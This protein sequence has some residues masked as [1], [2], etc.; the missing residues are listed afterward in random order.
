VELSD[1]GSRAKSD[2]IEAMHT[3]RNEMTIVPRSNNLSESHRAWS[4]GSEEIQL[5]EVRQ[6]ESGK[7]VQC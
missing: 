1:G 2:D 3:S 4:L 5:V 6:L 7:I